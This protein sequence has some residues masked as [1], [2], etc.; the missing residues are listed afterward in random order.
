MPWDRQAPHQVPLLTKECS[1]SPAF[2]LRQAQCCNRRV[3]SHLRGGGG[4][5]CRPWLGLHSPCLPDWHSPHPLILALPSSPSVLGATS[6][7]VPTQR[8]YSVREH[9][10]CASF[11]PK[12]DSPIHQLFIPLT[13]MLALALWADTDLQV[14]TGHRRG[15]GTDALIYKF[16][17]RV[18]DLAQW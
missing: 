3:P 9:M 1:G 5:C 7:P 4:S 2:H 17:S 14:A 11:L 6:L 10:V 8:S 12:P 15:Q 18:G 13:Q 16:I